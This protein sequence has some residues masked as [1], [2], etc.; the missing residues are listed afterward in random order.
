[1]FGLFNDLLSRVRDVKHCQ[2]VVCSIMPSP[3]NYDA[4]DKYFRGLSTDLKKLTHTFRHRSTFLNLGQVL[5][6]EDGVK[7]KTELYEEDGKYPGEQNRVHLTSKGAELVA[8]R[9][10]THLM[11]LTSGRFEN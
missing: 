11:Q 5:R 2:I 9:I 6:H 8:I 4:C 10:H 1:M 7:I 3:K